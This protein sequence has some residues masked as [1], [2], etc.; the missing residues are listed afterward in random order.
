M[1]AVLSTMQDLGGLAK[2]FDL[3]DVA[4]DNRIVALNDLAGQ[5][6]LLM[7]I[8]NHCPFVLHL[9]DKL[10]DIA[11]QAQANGFFVAAISSND[12]QSYPQDAP[13]KMIEFANNYGFCFPYLF[14]ESQ[15]A[16]KSYSAACTPDFFVY[17]KQHKLAYR[18]QMDSARPTNTLPVSG[19]DLSQALYAVLNGNKPPAQQLPS[20]GCNI[21]WKPGN[22]PL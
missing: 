20:I 16:A 18:G 11:N 3:P 5:A 13:D 8:C 10:T 6:V 4:N 19:D 15:T 14:D 9:I 7:F 12:I 1:V 17:D 21:K 22:E 2:P